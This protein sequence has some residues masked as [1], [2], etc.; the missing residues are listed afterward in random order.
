MRASGIKISNGFDGW[1]E[2]KLGNQE[3]PLISLVHPVDAYFSP[4]HLRTNDLRHSDMMNI[5]DRNVSI[6][7]KSA[8]AQRSAGFP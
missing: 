2:V 6:T 7:K 5:I 3:L 1:K 8:G 4:V